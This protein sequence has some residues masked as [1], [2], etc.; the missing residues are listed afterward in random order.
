MKNIMLKI[1]LVVFSLIET[2]GLKKVTS[3][4]NIYFMH[5]ISRLNVSGKG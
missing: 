2:Q 1:N 3:F 5:F 4:F